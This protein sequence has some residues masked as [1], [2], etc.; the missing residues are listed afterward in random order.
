M[1]QLEAPALDL[2]LDLT[3]LEGAARKWADRTRQLAIHSPCDVQD[4][5]LSVVAIQLNSAR[6]HLG[7]G[8]SDKAREALRIA[9]NYAS[10][11]EANTPQLTGV[12]QV[13]E[14]IRTLQD[15]LPA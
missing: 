14:A 6:H 12:A 7:R 11:E 2:Q 1:Q 4:A 13:V 3:A 15:S 5:A 10:S 8:D 9:R